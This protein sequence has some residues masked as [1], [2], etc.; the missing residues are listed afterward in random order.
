MKTISAREL[1]DALLASSNYVL[2]DV[3]EPHEVA[4]CNIEG[5]KNMPMSDIVTHKEQLKTEDEIVV[6]CHHGMRSAQVGMYLEQNGFD[7][8]TNLS[9]GIDAWA[10]DVDP[11][12]NRY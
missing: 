1:H 11:N 5:S 6:I 2:I 3:R 8:I 4:I 7:N 9:G 12:M 10:T